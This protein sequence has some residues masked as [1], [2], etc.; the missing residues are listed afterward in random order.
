[1]DADA[2]PVKGEIVSVAREYWA[3][4]VFVASYKNRMADPEEGHWVYVD[5][6]RESADIYIANHAETG[7]IVVTQDIGLASLVLPKGASALTPRGTIYTESSI[8][9]ALDLRYLAAKERSRGRYG[10]GPKRFTAE[11]REHFA[12][13]LAEM[14]SKMEQKGCFRGRNNSERENQ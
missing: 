3:A 5:P 12:R 9:P 13:A 11:D 7:D 1:V 6:H 2:C 8:G 10:K 14:L 4:V